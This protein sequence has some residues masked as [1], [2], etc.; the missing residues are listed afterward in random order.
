MKSGPVKKSDAI[1]VAKTDY[2]CGVNPINWNANNEGVA[3]DFYGKDLSNSVTAKSNCGV[4]CQQ[5]AGCTHYS[6]TT[7][8]G[9]TCWLKSGSATKYD[10]LYNGDS[11]TMCG[12]R[13]VNWN[14]AN[15]AFSCDFGGGD[16]ANAVVAGSQCS[17]KCSQTSGCT[18][19]VW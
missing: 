8:N 6:W 14:G 3:C 1:S 9:G 10:A 15:W 12:F 4:K 19:Y 7:L 5:T 11:N 17:T 2:V 18:H 16:F 13:G